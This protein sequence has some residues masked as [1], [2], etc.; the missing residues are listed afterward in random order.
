G[1]TTLGTLH[2]AEHHASRPFAD[3]APDLPRLARQL[4]NFLIEGHEPGWISRRGGAT[5]DRRSGSR[6]AGRAGAG[7]ED[8]EELELP[9]D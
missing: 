3:H 8:D 1:H 9:L 4:L 7:S 2:R 6:S 5:R